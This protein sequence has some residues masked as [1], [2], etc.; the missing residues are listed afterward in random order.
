MKEFDL[1][2]AKVGHPVCTRDGK[3]A[4]IL[5]FDRIGHHPIVALVKEAGDETIFSYNKKG[6]FSNDGRGCMCDLFMKAVKREAWINLYK[7]KESAWSVAF[8]SHI[9]PRNQECIYT[10]EGGLNRRYCIPYNEETAHLVGETDDYEGDEI[11]KIIKEC[12]LTEG[13][14]D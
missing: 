5:C 9:N 10:I 13:K 7:D 14:L 4:R 6:R 2:K 11:E 8:F 12:K 3:E 1:E